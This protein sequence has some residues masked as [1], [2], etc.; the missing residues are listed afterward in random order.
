[1]KRESSIENAVCNYAKAHGWLVRKVQWIGR[2]G[3]PDRMFARS[4]RVVFIEFKAP[5]RP[6]RPTQAREIERLRKEGIEAW[7]CDDA[8]A[9]ISLLSGGRHTDVA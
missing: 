2:V 7:L 1:M 9:G 3:A 4:G 8:E 5:G 6:A